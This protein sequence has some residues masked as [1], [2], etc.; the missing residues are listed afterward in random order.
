MID[1]G[2]THS[3]WYDGCLVLTLCYTLL[4]GMKL[5]ETIG[6]VGWVMLIFSFHWY[7]IVLHLHSDH[8]IGELI[9]SM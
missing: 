9:W 2:E 1:D 7:S 4:N 8:S 5:K 3:H 6:D